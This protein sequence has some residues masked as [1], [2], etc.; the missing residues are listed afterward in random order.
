MTEKKLSG[1]K[2]FGTDGIRARFG[3][4]PLDNESIIKL[5][6]AIGQWAQ[7][8]YTSTKNDSML[9][10]LIGHDTRISCDNIK[11][12]LALGLLNYNITIHDAQII[13]T[14]A[15]VKIINNKCDYFN[16]GI[17]ITASHNPYH[18]NG[19]KIVDSKTGKLEKI[20]EDKITEN[21]YNLAISSNT[22]KT[23]SIRNELT[24]ES[25]NYEKYKIIKTLQ[26][27]YIKT[28]TSYFKK[29]TLKNI[30]I[31]LDCA[32]GA[33]YKVAP[34]IFKQLGANILTVS[35][36]PDGKNINQDCGSTH[37]ENL[38]KFMLNNNCDI[39]FAFDGDGDRIAAI[40]KNNQTK[41]GDDILCLLSQHP[42]YKNQ[43]AIV[44]TIISNYGLEI[45]LNK[46][47]KKLIRAN[48]GDKDVCKELNHNNLLVGGEPSGHI[49]LRNYLSCGDGIFAA[50][51]LIEGIKNTNNWDLKTF[52]RT[53]QITINIKVKEKKDLNEPKLKEIILKYKNKLNNGRL[54]VRYSGTEDLLRIMTE[55]SDKNLAQE[56]CNNLSTELAQELNKQ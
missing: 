52:E 5:G 13:P 32:N 4:F 47:N 49:V 39:G 50:L 34:K 2:I 37:P 33:T 18:D 48:V 19:I 6:L 3:Q 12:N 20:D 26:E 45:Y 36:T 25:N 27:E 54:I 40:S 29:N 46:N 35:N 17:I 56:I 24:E 55:S 42:D 22:N 31:A 43:T 28:I 44:G 15:I 51:K 16:F 41:D 9:N 14:P 10:I 7:E 11:Q 8:K 21:F 23:F 30:K 53:P 38:Q 1:A